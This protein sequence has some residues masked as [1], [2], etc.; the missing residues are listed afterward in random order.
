MGDFQLQLT[1][2]QQILSSIQ[3]FDFGI[4]EVGF[5]V[6]WG[7]FPTMGFSPEVPF[8]R[9]SKLVKLLGKKISVSS[10]LVTDSLFQLFIQYL[11]EI[12]CYFF[13][14]LKKKMLI[15]HT[16]AGEDKVL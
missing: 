4:E 1:S 6:R 16:A 11:T 5:E 3:H 15:N 9:C 2:S 7:R 10:F 12:G 13:I 8:S 14:L